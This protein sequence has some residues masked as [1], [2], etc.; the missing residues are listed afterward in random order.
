M[1]LNTTSTFPQPSILLHPDQT[2]GEPVVCHAGYHCPQ[3]STEESKCPYGTYSDAGAAECTPC[4]VIESDAFWGYVDDS[5]DGIDACGARIDPDQPTSTSHWDEFATFTL[6]TAMLL[7]IV[8]FC[9]TCCAG[10]CLR[11]CC[12]LLPLLLD[13]P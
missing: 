3:G 2:A 7:S 4:P 13:L 12:T 11:C 9:V 5:R 6:L 1:V 10:C 8:L